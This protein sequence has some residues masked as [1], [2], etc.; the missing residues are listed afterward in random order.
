[1]KARTTSVEDWVAE[2]FMDTVPVDLREQDPWSV[3]AL[4]DNKPGSDGLPA[5]HSSSLEPG[6]RDENGGVA[7]PDEGLF[8]VTEVGDSLEEPFKVLRDVETSPRD[9]WDYEQ[10]PPDALEAADAVGEPPSSSDGGI[11]DADSLDEPEPVAEYED[12]LSEALYESDVDGADLP[13]LIAVDE[14]MNGVEEATP[15]QRGEVGELLGELSKRRLF[16]LLRWMEGKTWTGDSLVLF[17]ELRAL[18]VENPQWW[19]CT[20]WSSRINHWWTYWNAST[21]SRDGCYELVQSRL[22]CDADEIIDQRWLEDWENLELWKH[23]FASFAAFA[24]FRAGLRE[25]EDWKA[26]LGSRDEFDSSTDS[27]SWDAFDGYRAGG[28]D[29]V[30]FSSL[31]GVPQCRENDSPYRHPHGRTVWFAVQDWYDAAEWHDGLGWPHSWVGARHPYLL[32]G[33]PEMPDQM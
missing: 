22:D 27:G 3:D 9:D 18:W 16:N 12:D 32:P 13:R 14:F 4:R 28:Y 11:L 8:G 15:E 5:S 10:A 20:F 25:G 1:M 7:D 33:S 21:L 30:L 31:A 24:I 29:E 26:H 6:G 19:E 17:L 2:D 23:G